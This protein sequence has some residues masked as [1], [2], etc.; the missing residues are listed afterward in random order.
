MIRNLKNLYPRSNIVPIDYDPGA[1]VN[2]E[3]RIKL[4][5]AV[6]KGKHGE[7][8][9]KPNA[10]LWRAFLGIGCPNGRKRRRWRF[11]TAKDWRRG[12]RNGR[13]CRSKSSRGRCTG[14]A[15]TGICPPC[16]A[17]RR[18]W[19]SICLRPCRRRELRRTAKNGRRGSSGCGGSAA[20]CC[21]K[22]AEPRT[23]F[24]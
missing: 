16:T 24:P 22:Q 3:N 10:C 12:G 7:R 6:A 9:I 11:F 21:A 8:R 4:M 1:T 23:R 17:V 19:C 2:Q 20:G 14:T 18:A 13:V 15:R 5:L